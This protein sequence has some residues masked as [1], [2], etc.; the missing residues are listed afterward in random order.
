MMYVV[1]QEEEVV[2]SAAAS[3]VRTHK[4]P[5]LAGAWGQMHSKEVATARWRVRRKSCTVTVSF[6]L[7]G[8]GSGCFGKVPGA[9]L[10]T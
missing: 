3:V 5:S 2:A 8:L 4:L 6:F 1:M 9:L 7:L 10:V